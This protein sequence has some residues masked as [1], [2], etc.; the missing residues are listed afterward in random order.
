[1]KNRMAI[2]IILLAAGMA[3]AKQAKQFQS[4]TLMQMESVKCG[5]DENSGKSFAGELIGTDSGHKKTQELLC[6]EYVLQSDRLVYRIRPRD[7]KH[8]ALLPV[9]QKVQFRVDKD[10]MVLR[11]EDMDN[12]DRDYTVVSMTARTG[13]ETAARN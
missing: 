1:M 13:V 12:K 11:V 3:Q 2:T 9:G 5:V 10:K 4:G 6:Q 8:P 7:A